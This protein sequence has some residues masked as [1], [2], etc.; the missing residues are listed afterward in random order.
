MSLKHGTSRRIFFLA[1]YQ[2]LIP[3][4]RL[5]LHWIMQ[6]TGQSQQRSWAHETFGSLHKS[7]W[8]FQVSN[9]FNSRP[10]TTQSSDQRVF[11]V[12]PFALPVSSIRYFIF[13]GR[14]LQPHSSAYSYSLHYT[15][16]VFITF[17]FL[18]SMFYIYC[19][20]IL[21]SMILRFSSI[22]WK[23]D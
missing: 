11:A 6:Y 19:L 12:K 13:L 8:A 16:S 10:L 1:A 21:L 18:S 7:N 3:I 2:T 17:P 22:L 14:V 4:R 23:H 9:T 20:A 5:K 15:M